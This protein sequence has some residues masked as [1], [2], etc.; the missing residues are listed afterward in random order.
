[1]QVEEPLP[2]SRLE[3]PIRLQAGVGV[4][5][6]G[7]S[8]PATPRIISVPGEKDGVDIVDMVSLQVGFCGLW[9]AE[10]VGS[11]H[12]A[13]AEELKPRNFNLVVRTGTGNS[14]VTLHAA[15]T[16]THHRRLEV[17]FQ[18]YFVRLVA[19]VFRGSIIRYLHLTSD[20]SP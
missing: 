6:A 9:A 4:A 10:T 2:E 1:M 20:P 13:D 5:P 12:A 16:W 19:Q 17:S 8:D 7:P 18:G 11:E 3:R 15:G 14:G